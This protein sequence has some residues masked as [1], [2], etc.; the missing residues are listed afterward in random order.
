MFNE[1]LIIPKGKGGRKIL[2][3]IDEPIDGDITDYLGNT[4][5]YHEESCVHMEDGEYTFN[6]A[7]SYA[8]YLAGLEE[9]EET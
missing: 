3:Y 8:A 4:A 1:E 5:H 9:S 6:I 7:E 2:T